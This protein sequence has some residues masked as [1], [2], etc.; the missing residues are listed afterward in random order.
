MQIH[1]ELEE[2]LRDRAWSAA[3]RVS[4]GRNIVRLSAGKRRK[5]Y[6]R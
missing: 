2:H 5:L 4:I 6:F 1:I 3:S